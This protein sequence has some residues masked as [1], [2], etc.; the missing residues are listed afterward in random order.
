MQRNHAPARSRHRRGGGG[1][2]G[3]GGRGVRAPH[4]G[5]LTE[6]ADC[7]IGG[8]STAACDRRT[9]QRPERAA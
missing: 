4:W 2:G 1:W 8:A 5:T 3:R 9:H 7:C 6:A